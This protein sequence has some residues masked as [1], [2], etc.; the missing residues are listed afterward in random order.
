MI[1][2]CPLL[3]SQSGQP[4]LKLAPC[5]LLLAPCSLLLAAGCLLLAPCSWLLAACPLLLADFPIG[6]T[7]PQT[8]SFLLPACSLLL[9]RSQLVTKTCYSSATLLLAPCSFLLAACCLLLAAGCS[10]FPSLSFACTFLSFDSPCFCL[11][12]SRV[13]PPGSGTTG[14]RSVF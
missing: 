11:N 5:S 4:G 1:A 3:L 14:R 8:C 2:A 13:F 10:P 9:S 6:S 12:V 7:W